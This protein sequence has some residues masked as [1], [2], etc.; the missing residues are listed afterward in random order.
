MLASEHF[1]DPAVIASSLRSPVDLLAGSM[2]AMQTRQGG[3][4]DMRMTAQEAHLSAATLG[5][6]L[7]DPPGVQGWAGYRSWIST[8]WLPQRHHFTDLLVDGYDSFVLEV[9]GEIESEPV[10]VGGR[11]GM[12][13][14]AYARQWEGFVDDPELLVDNI[15]AHLLAYPASFRLREHLVSALMQQAPYYEWRSFSDELKS[16]RLRTMLK[17]L[18]RSAN[19]QLM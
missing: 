2:R 13:I 17:L 3:G 12:D 11:S 5:Q 6:A 16:T 9:Q 4:D 19:Y 7:F 8:S 15:T 1:Y 18:M 14:L 10:I